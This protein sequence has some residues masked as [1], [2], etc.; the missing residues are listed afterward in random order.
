[1]KTVKKTPK[2]YPKNSK[3]IKTTILEL[4]TKD[5]VHKVKKNKRLFTVSEL[6]NI[7]LDILANTRR[8]SSSQNTKEGEKILRAINIRT[9]ET[10]LP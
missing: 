7:A 8:P 5:S 2:Q 4:N 1:M 10:K 6:L 9:E 3:S